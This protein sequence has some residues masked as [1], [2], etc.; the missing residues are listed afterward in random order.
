MEYFLGSAI[1]LVSLFVFNHMLKKITSD[2]LRVP[3]FTQTARVELLKN[4]LISVVARKP[5]EETQAR[6]HLKENSMRAFFLGKDVYWIENGFLFTAKVNNN[7][8]DESTKKIVD[9]HSIDKV[10]LDK[11][12]FIVDKLTEGNKDDSGNSGK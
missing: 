5:E 11:I 8:V 12:S 10:E 1:T 2:N 4:Y 3:I 9:T 6:N 7:E